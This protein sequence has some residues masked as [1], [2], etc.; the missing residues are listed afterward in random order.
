MPT[1]SDN[2]ALFL[3]FV[4]CGHFPRIS[5]A[6]CVLLL[7]SD[8][9][10]AASAM[11][12]AGRPM[13]PVRT[14]CGDVAGTSGGGHGFSAVLNWSRGSYWLGQNSASGDFRYPRANRG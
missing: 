4:K 3:N 7:G 13:Y 2:T 1:T 8:G 10:F 11:F 6:S 14:Y 12:T 9:V 5:I